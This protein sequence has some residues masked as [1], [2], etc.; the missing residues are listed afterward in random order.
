MRKT[1]KFL[2]ACF[3]IAAKYQKQMGQVVKAE[4]NYA[5][6]YLELQ[7]DGYRWNSQEQEW[8]LRASPT[9]PSELDIHRMPVQIRIIAQDTSAAGTAAQYVGDMIKQ[10]GGMIEYTSRAHE[11]RD[12]GGERIY[13]E[14]L[15]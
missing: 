4:T 1:M 2:R 8:E 11:N 7:A 14:V 6:V 12:G 15:L 3:I 13:L 5:N 10:G 9:N